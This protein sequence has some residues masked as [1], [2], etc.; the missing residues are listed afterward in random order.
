MVTSTLESQWPL[1]PRTDQVYQ[2]EI[3]QAAYYQVT[4]DQ[5]ICAKCVLAAQ[6]SAACLLLVGANGKCSQEGRMITNLVVM[7]RRH[8]SEASCPFEELPSTASSSWSAA[9]RCCLA[10][11]VLSPCS[12]ASTTASCLTSTCMSPRQETVICFCQ[13]EHLHSRAPNQSAS[14]SYKSSTHTTWAPCQ[15]QRKAA[16]A[17]KFSS[18][19]ALF[20]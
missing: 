20:Y 5:L 2:H 4:G 1:F 7:D 8:N 14:C 18:L 19:G 6:L 12:D 3:F 17:V 16:C 9:P 10:V 15:G 11:S 13:K